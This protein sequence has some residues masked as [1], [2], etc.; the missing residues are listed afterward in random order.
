MSEQREAHGDDAIVRNLYETVGERLPVDAF[1]RAMVLAWLCLYWLRDRLSVRPVLSLYGPAGSGKTTAARLLV[2]LH[3]AEQLWTPAAAKRKPH[4]VIGGFD[5]IEA[6]SDWEAVE[7]WCLCAAAGG[8]PLAGSHVLSAFG[9]IT[10]VERVARWA[11]PPMVPLLF[12][13]PCA[14]MYHSAHMGGYHS[15]SKLAADMARLRTDLAAMVA[16]EADGWGRYAEALSGQVPES[17]IAGRQRLT[18]AYMSLIAEHLQWHDPRVLH[19]PDGAPVV[20]G[21][22]FARRLEVGINILAELLLRLKVR[23][24]PQVF[25]AEP[26]AERKHRLRA[27]LAIA[28]VQLADVARDLKLSPAALHGWARNGDSS[29]RGAVCAIDIAES[30]TRL[31]AVRC[32][33]E[34]LEVGSDCRPGWGVGA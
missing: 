3:G 9:L 16:R 29:R 5:N 28:G 31:G 34:A 18:L 19:G 10:S 20:S 13:V 15:R 8:E 17:H 7:D 25:S 30:I 21:G 12:P 6:G 23:L 22:A 4:E 27:A 32:P 26:A 24:G 2:G 14:P 11:R 33:A 1:D